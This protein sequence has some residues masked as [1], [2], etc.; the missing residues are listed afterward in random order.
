MPAASPLSMF[1]YLVIFIEIENFIKFLFCGHEISPNEKLVL[2][3]TDQP[4]HPPPHMKILILMNNIW[5][6]TVAYLKG[7]Y[8]HDQS[9]LSTG[10][11]IS[12]L[13]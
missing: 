8:R 5:P 9:R 11:G 2:H 10:H 4:P 12:G 6:S 3:K 13:V 1:H 7:Q